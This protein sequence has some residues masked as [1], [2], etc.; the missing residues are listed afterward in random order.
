[1]NIDFKHALYVNMNYKND[2]FTTFILQKF[3]ADIAIQYSL[4]K[5]HQKQYN[6]DINMYVNYITKVFI[7]YL[8]YKS[9]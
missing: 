2:T 4:F 8:G 9:Q 7:T 1:M 6:N 3:I 5:V